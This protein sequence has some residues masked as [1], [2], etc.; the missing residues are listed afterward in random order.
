[1]RLYELA[2]NEARGAGLEYEAKVFEAMSRASIPGLVI[3]KSSAGFS[4]HGAGDIEATYNGMPFNVEV[5]QSIADQM[6]SGMMSYDRPSGKITPSQKMASSVD[7]DD[8]SV[9]VEATQSV[10]PAIDVY[11]D[12]LAHTE[13]TVFHSNQAKKGVSFVAAKS[14][15]EQLR[16][17]GLMRPIN[18]RINV[19]SDFIARKYNSKGANYIQIGR[20]GLYYLGSNPLGLPIPEFTGS[21]TVEIRLKRAGD[22]LGSVTKAFNNAIGNQDQPIQARRVDLVATGRF[23]GDLLP[24]PFTLDDPN[25][26]RKLYEQSLI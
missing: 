10:A 3:N 4:A 13:P 24:S 7:P 8:L 21:A 18:R 14:A 22:S 26:I 17:A 2:I 6:G 23:K 16:R 19:S 1:M 5:K 9:I 25:S 15:L 20:K 11:L 12:A